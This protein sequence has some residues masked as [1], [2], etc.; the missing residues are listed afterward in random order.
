M[1]N[2]HFKK[3]VVQQPQK[4]GLRGCKALTSFKRLRLKQPPNPP[5]S[6]AGQALC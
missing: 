4:R 5:A 2:T 3:S 6:S 1:L